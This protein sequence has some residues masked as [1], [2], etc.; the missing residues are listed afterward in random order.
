MNNI[1]AQNNPL[2]EPVKGQRLILDTEYYQIEGEKSLFSNI[3]ES[4]PFY[5]FA[6]LVLL[7]A[8]GYG[9]YLFWKSNKT[10][11]SKKK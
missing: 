1:F 3:V 9:V 7:I 10:T 11:K 2:P 4:K 8:C 5:A 6:F